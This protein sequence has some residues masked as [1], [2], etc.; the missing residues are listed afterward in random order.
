M[1]A[2][3]LG[4]EIVK[5]IGETR[6]GEATRKRARRR[7][8]VLKATGRYQSTM[9]PRPA[10]EERSPKGLGADIKCGEKMKFQAKPSSAYQQFQSSF[11]SGISRRHD[12]GKERRGFAEGIPSVLR[13]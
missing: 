1:L 2:T 3:A 8:G 4:R 9:A 5:G 12:A 10:R 6:A 7:R 13:E 11:D